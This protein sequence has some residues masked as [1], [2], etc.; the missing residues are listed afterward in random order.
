MKHPEQS[1][2]QETDPA[3]TPSHLP[4]TKKPRINSERSQESLKTP[5]VASLGGVHISARKSHECI[6]FPPKRP[7]ALPCIGF[8]EFLKDSSHSSFHRNGLPP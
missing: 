8:I 4:A 6:R 7:S 3:H 5:T 2:G 1:H